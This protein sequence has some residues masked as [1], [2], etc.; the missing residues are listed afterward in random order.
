MVGRTPARQ[1]PPGRAA[2]ENTEPWEAVGGRQKHKGRVR[3]GSG[4]VALGGGGRGSLVCWGCAR[5]LTET[6]RPQFAS[7]I[8]SRTSE[9]VPCG[10]VR[11]SRP[12]RPAFLLPPPRRPCLG[13]A[14]SVKVRMAEPQAG[15]SAPAWDVGWAAGRGRRTEPGQKWPPRHRGRTGGGGGGHREARRAAGGGGVLPQVC[16]HPDLPRPSPRP[17]LEVGQTEVPPSRVAPRMAGDLVRGLWTQRPGEAPA[18][19]AQMGGQPRAR[20]EGTGAPAH[21]PHR[22][23]KEPGLLLPRPEDMCRRSLEMR[24]PRRA[25]GTCGGGQAAGGP[26]VTGEPPASAAPAKFMKRKMSRSRGGNVSRAL[27]LEGSRRR[28]GSVPPPPPA[29]GDSGAEGAVASSLITGVSAP[30]LNEGPASSWKDAHRGKL[31]GPRCTGPAT[32]RGR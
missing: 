20:P 11:G 32:P 6:Q 5:G 19:V 18:D 21:R 24:G 16:P 31:R 26:D 1:P 2:L 28:E 8:G 17:Y 9:D 23:R 10:P 15:D 30:R 14:F 27:L 12:P 3:P 25:H 7:R 29:R 22:P 4:G 13:R